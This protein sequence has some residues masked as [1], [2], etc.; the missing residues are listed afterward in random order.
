MC[1]FYW[2]F[3]FCCNKYMYA[4]QDSEWCG[5]VDCSRNEIVTKY[6]VIMCKICI[7]IGC[8]NK[9]QFCDIMILPPIIYKGHEFIL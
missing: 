7:E 3:C 6:D 8:F 2:C 9:K 4:Y 1:Q 5:D